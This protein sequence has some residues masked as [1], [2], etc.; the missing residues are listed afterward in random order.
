MKGIM[1]K[2]RMGLAGAALLF[3]VG[4]VSALDV[5]AEG[6]GNSYTVSQ[7]LYS[8]S[9]DASTDVVRGTGWQKVNGKWRYFKKDGTYYKNKWIQDKGKWYYLD[10]SGY[11]AT[12]W[13]QISGKWYYFRADGSMVSEEFVDG[14]W[15]RKDGS[16]E[17]KKASWK[18]SG[19]RWW[20]GY[21]FGWYAKNAW[22]TIDGK[23]YYFY[24]SGYL[25]V[26]QWIGNYYVGGDG[27]YVKNPV[28]GKKKSVAV[29][30]LKNRNQL[31]WLLEDCRVHNPVE[32]TGW[33]SIFFTMEYASALYP[34]G[35]VKYSGASTDPLNKF[36]WLCFRV[37]ADKMKWYASSV[38]NVPAKNM[39][40]LEKDTESYLFYRYGSY[41][42]FKEPG[43]GGPGIENIE[44]LKVTT[45]GPYYYCTYSIV[46]SINGV[47]Q[48]RN[49]Y[50]A[51]VAR[52]Y[53]N[54][55]YYWSIFSGKKLN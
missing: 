51:V 40:L 38:L 15:L 5:R 48:S 34:V 6:A 2:V 9:V 8:L 21:S 20:F 46:Y 11:M 55:T 36:P 12:G 3:C 16:A 32:I 52:K 39:K 41:Y 49:K 17:S 13:K 18:P 22:Y 33:N 43:I 50:S 45:D 1:R 10:G 4:S 44:D 37:P 31:E 47:E 19:T 23:E 28:K 35:C 7:S 24:P 42:Y 27:A 53:E 14:Y 30:S 26:S 29:S 54:G 25:A